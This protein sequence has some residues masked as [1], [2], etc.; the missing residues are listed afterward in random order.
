MVIARRLSFILILCSYD[1][2]FG[3]N[4][5]PPPAHKGEL[6]DPDRALPVPFCFQGFFPPPL[7]SLRVF[8]EAVPCLLLFDCATAALCTK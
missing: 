7:T 5:T 4:D 6:L 2:G 1:L 8:V 3:P